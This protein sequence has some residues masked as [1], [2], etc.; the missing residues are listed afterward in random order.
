MR[1]IA[2]IGLGRFGMALAKTLSASGVQVV[3]IDRDGKS[4]NEIK[5]DVDIAVR[6]DSTDQAVL[7]SQDLDKVDVCVIAIG[8]QFESAL[9]TTVLAKQIG[10]PEVIC[11]A[12]SEFHAEIFQKIGAD[13]IIQPEK[14][15]GE[16]LA[17]QLSN[18]Q[19]V[20][21]IQ[22]ADG[23]T[24]MEFRAPKTFHGKS[25]RELALR[26]RY[27]VNLVVIRREVAG[28]TDPEEA[29]VLEAIF[30]YA[31]EELRENDILVV[32]GSDEALTR[33]PRE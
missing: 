12:Q 25:I 19:L 27:E 7:L 13:K 26:N 22:L 24:L 2:V 11:R 15:S 28:K 20:D 21:F 14:V 17:R 30:P 18:P 16:S 5:D 23:F 10:I 32:V 31:D 1:K 4:V 8:E 29:P 6:G 3:A 9:L 33:L